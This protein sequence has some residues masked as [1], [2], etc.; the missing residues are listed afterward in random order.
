MKKMLCIG[1]VSLMSTQV[2][3][4]NLS[5][6]AAKEQAAN[7]VIK[8]QLTPVTKAATS[9][10]GKVQAALG[11]VPMLTQSLGVTQA[12]ATGGI[13][14]IFQAAKGLMP[15]NDFGTLSKAVPNMSSLLG[16]APAVTAPKQG[17]GNLLSGALGAAAQLG[18]NTQVGA[19][20]LSQFQA[21]GLSPDMISKFADV[22]MTYLQ[23]GEVPQAADL[24]S[25]ALSSVIPSA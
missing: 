7:K 8:E 12:Q 9:S 11:L 17:S 19:Q 5:T 3:A 15:A 10:K 18:A 23:K 2:Y 25:A 21:L 13:G 1:L 20:L 4:D 14:S 16:A 22:A 24:L 6:L